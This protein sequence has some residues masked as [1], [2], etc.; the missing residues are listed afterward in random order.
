[1][2]NT[3]L[4]KWL[5]SFL[6][7]LFF[8]EL[9][10]MFL[11]HLVHE[12]LGMLFLTLAIWHNVLNRRFY[13][14]IC[15]GAY[16]FHRVGNSLDII[17]LVMFFVLIAISGMVLSHD[18]F[19]QFYIAGD[20]N[21]RSLHLGGAIGTLILLCSHLLFQGKRYI[22][23]RGYTVAMGL[24]FVLA[25]AGIFGLPY[26]DRWYNPVHVNKA[27]LAQ[28]EKV[29]IPGKI[30]T[31]YFSRVGNTD[32]P[33]DVDAVSGASVMKD[34]QEL[35]GNAEMIAYMVKDAAG[36]DLFAIRTE[37]TYPTDYGETTQE[38]QREI[39]S[40]IAPALREPLP[41]LEDYDVIFLVYPLW[42]NTLPMSI[43][44]LLN[45]YDLAGKTIIP[46]VTHG[47]SGIGDSLDAIRRATKAEVKN[48]YLDIYS[49]DIPSSR[50]AIAD[51]LKKFK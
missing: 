37:K 47:G 38:G 43:E 10:G 17:L 42:W 16:S 11:P 15:R 24:G 49:S 13:Q 2:N 40:G 27:I 33:T 7:I 35:I 1:M 5:A 4:R 26:L 20:V 48:E 50:Q 8:A 28:G 23:G 31:V 19:P 22:R 46:I 30:I 18:L 6:L 34:G 41:Q 51:Y 3:A 29:Q 45:Q 32:F 9:G 21:W 12:L 25:A 44:G 14:S 36:G 39:E